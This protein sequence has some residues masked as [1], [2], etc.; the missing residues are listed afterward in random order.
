[1]AHALGVSVTNDFRLFEQLGG[2]IAG[3]LSLWPEGETPP[4][5]K[6]VAATGTGPIYRKLGGRVVYAVADLQAW[7]DLDIRRPASD[8]RR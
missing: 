6:G 1:M 2:D 5:T 8:C 4:P 7:A 3:A